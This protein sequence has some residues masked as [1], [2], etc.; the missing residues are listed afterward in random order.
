MEEI[1]L[2]IAQ[3]SAIATVAVFAIW[4]ISNVTIALAQALVEVSKA[5]AQSVQ[6]AI[7]HAGD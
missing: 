7:E 6:E 3:D 5:N 2:K 4:R 1:V